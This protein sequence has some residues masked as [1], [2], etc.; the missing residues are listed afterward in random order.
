MSI[1]RPFRAFRPAPKLAPSIAALPY[2][3]YNSAEARS[4]VEAE[5][6]SFLKIDRAETLLNEGTD[7]YSEKVYE[8]ARTVLDG[9]IQ[10]GSFIQEETDCNYIYAL[11]MNGRTQT[12]LVGCAS[13]DDYLNGVILRH[14]NTLEAKEQDRI[15]HIDTCSAQTG[16]IFLTHRPNEELRHILNKIKQGTVLYDFTS[17][18]AVRHQIWKIESPEDIEN[19]FRLYKETDHL[20]I[21]DGHHR[22]ASAVKVGLSRR[23]ANPGSSGTEEYNFFLSVLFP[24]D[25]LAIYGYDRVVTDKNGYTISE[26]FDKIKDSFNIIVTENIPFRPSRKGEFGVY[27]AGMWHRLQAKPDMISGD[28]VKGLDVSILQEHILSPVLGIHDPKTDPRIRFIGEIKGFNALEQAADESGGI[29]F[30]MHPT[31]MEEL[32]R[33]ADHG[34]LMPPKSTWFEPKLRDGLSLFV[35]IRSIKYTKTTLE[36]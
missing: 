20:Y 16:P 28:P 29:A 1:I 31:S 17:N 4:I 10:D 36:I 8:T 26:F 7:I 5:P 23:A 14:E 3:V 15:R 30:S 19:I 35:R 27:S 21:A 13:I 6:M 22:A 34:L 2:D 9:M 32:L 18:D 11:T 33:I 24:S 25:E 12:G